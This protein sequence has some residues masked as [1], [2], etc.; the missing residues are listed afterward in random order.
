MS[1]ATSAA[2]GVLLAYKQTVHHSDES[3]H[4][5]MIHAHPT[6]SVALTPLTWKF[7]VYVMYVPQT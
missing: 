7:I 4:G 3:I 5:A 2:I 1:P 6:L